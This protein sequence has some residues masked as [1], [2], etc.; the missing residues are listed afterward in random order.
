MIVRGVST[1][2]SKSSIESSDLNEAI[3]HNLDI[4]GGSV[5]RLKG[6]SFVNF[7]NIHSF[8]IDYTYM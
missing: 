4:I 7:I 5:T 6:N 8:L 1:S 3:N 2:Q